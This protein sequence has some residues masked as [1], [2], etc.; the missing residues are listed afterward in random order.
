MEKFLQGIS[1]DNEYLDSIES[2]FNTVINE[3]GK[4]TSRQVDEI[5]SKVSNIET[6]LTNLLNK[7]AMIN[8]DIVIKKLSEEIEN[9]ETQKNTLK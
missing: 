2:T 8:S 6:N 4:D 1:L 3:R 9:L 7:I 5:K